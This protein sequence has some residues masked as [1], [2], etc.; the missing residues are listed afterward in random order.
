MICSKNNSASSSCVGCWGVV[1]VVLEC[2]YYVETVAGVHVVVAHV[3]E[4]CRGH[5]HGWLVV[6]IMIVCKQRGSGGKRSS[7][8]LSSKMR[9][10]KRH[11]RD[12]CQAAS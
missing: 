12:R 6:G 9:R 1:Q 2:S 11:I 4:V 5:H 7:H 3:V 10:D 8:H